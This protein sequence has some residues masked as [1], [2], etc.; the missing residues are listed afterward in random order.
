SKHGAVLFRGFGV[1]M[2]TEFERLA[3]ALSSSLY[4]D[5]GEHPRKSVSGNVYTPVFYPP[6]QRVLW[7]N[8]NS[9]NHHWPTKIWFGCIQPARRGGETP[10]A[11]SREVFRRMRPEVRERFAEKGVMYV[12]NYGSGLGLNWQDVFRT[13]DRAEVEEVC[14]RADTRFEWKEGDALKTVAVRPAVVAH[15]RT[16]EMSWFNQAQH[17]HVSCLDP[18]TRHSL[19]SIFGE[20]DLPRHCYYGDGTRIEDSVMEEILGVYRRIEVSFPWQKG[21]VMMIDN[22]L[23]AHARNQF[24]G[25]RRI[26]VAMGD[27]LSYDEV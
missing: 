23:A 21:D 15:P 6:E 3:Q 22:I 24:E 14:R 19:L 20:E 9:F 25:E 13:S 8:E 12:R 2:A 26:V 11:D 4:H 7:H 1:D 17:W 27:L 10:V 18:A 16:G 5:N